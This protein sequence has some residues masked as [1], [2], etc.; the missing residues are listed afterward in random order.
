MKLAVMGMALCSLLAIVLYSSGY[1]WA[2]STENMEC[3]NLVKINHTEVV[4]SNLGG[5]DPDKEEGIIYTM[6]LDMKDDTGKQFVK[7]ITL[8]IHATTKYDHHELHSKH[9]SIGRANRFFTVLMRSGSDLGFNIS[10]FDAETHKET[11][12]P[13]FELTFL[14]LDEAENDTEK[15]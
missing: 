6:H 8:E 11:K 10:V 5:I 4:S 9:F 3:D 12:L 7:K 1:L 13:Y 14:D 2:P 15:E